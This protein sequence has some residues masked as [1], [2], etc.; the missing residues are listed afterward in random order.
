MPSNLTSRA[1]NSLALRITLWYAGSFLIVSLAVSTISYFYLSSAVRDNRKIIQAK[2]NAV[3]A[4]ARER[5]VGAIGRFENV[6]SP[7][8]SRKTVF[9]RVVDDEIGRAHV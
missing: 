3:T 1:R 4:I 2:L 7:K 5:G 6:K 8:Y 9:I